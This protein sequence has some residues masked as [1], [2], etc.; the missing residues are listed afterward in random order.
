MSYNTNIK[1]VFSAFGSAFEPEDFTEFIGII[2]TNYWKK[3]DIISNYKK[4]RKRKESCWEYLIHSE[5]IFFEEISNIL[6]DI[7]KPKITDINK[8]NNISIKFDIILEI[9]EQQGISL[10]FNIPFLN[11]VNSL[12]GE[13]DVDIYNLRDE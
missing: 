4:N 1:I 8:F 3:G 5:T 9:A 10:Y 6:V 7:F 12:N 2:P 11:M 13:I